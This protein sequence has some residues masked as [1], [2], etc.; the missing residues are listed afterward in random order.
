MGGILALAWRSIWRNRRRTLISMC[1]IGIGLML[2]LVYG[3]LMAGILGDA[4]AQLDN[5]GMGHVEIYRTGWRPKHTTT[6]VIE[7]PEVVLKK[8]AVPP[9]S[10]LGARVVSKGLATSAHGS[11]GVEILGVDFGVE[12]HLSAHVRDVVAG[13][14]PGADDLHG[15]LIGERLAERLRVSVGGKVRLM[16][17]RAD[18]DVGVEL[19]R[20]RGVFH[21]IAASLSKRQVFVTSQSARELVGVEGAHRLIVQLQ[22]A[23]DAVA[24]AEA[25][26]AA[27][28]PEYEVVTYGQ[29]VPILEKMEAL[30]NNVVLVAALFV[31]ALVGLGILNTAIMSIFERTREFGVMLALGTRPRRLVMLVFAESF[32]I[33]TLSVALG[34]GLG[35][36]LTWYGSTHVLFDMSGAGE[37]FELGGAA[38]KTAMHTRFNL[39]DSFVSAALVYV[40]A[41]IV[42][43]Y[44]AYQVS[45]LLP[46][47]ALRRG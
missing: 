17:Q 15:I 38:M 9:G 10:E 32:W 28:G 6:R 31:Y 34:L 30:T 4:A 40:M 33:A 24:V 14:V 23:T 16:V 39:K 46:A 19:Y 35:L 27:L 41:L 37:A 7:A 1:A 13:A 5:S 36:S 45:R 47:E 29:L 43:L 12:K 26:R 44:P 22:L 8:L 3:G 42:G 25:A 11:D 20:V 2:V 18:G 21:S